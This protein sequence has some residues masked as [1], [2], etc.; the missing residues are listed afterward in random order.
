MVKTCHQHK[1]MLRDPTSRE[2]DELLD[3][4]LPPRVNVSTVAEKMA[5]GGCCLLVVLQQLLYN[6]SYSRECY[7]GCINHP[8]L[9]SPCSLLAELWSIESGF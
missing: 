3:V 1:C 9:L 5:S 2:H 7:H 8:I 6:R 4:A